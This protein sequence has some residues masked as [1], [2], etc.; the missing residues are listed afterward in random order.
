MVV[1][2]VHIAQSQKNLSLKRKTMQT[3][4]FST[5]TYP[6]SGLGAS[7]LDLQHAQTYIISFNLILCHVTDIN[8]RRK[9]LANPAN[10]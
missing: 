4:M 1:L 9:N 7:P 6:I 10:V 8:M 3:I 5:Q 2:K